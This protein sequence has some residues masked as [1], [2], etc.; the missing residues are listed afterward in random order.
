MRKFDLQKLTLRIN[1]VDLGEFGSGIVYWNE[2]LGDRALILTAKHCLT[3]RDFSRSPDLDQLKIEFKRSDGQWTTF[4]VSEALG[5][6]IDVSE[7][8]QDFGVIITD[9]PRL[10]AWLGSLVPMYLATN[11]DGIQSCTVAGFPWEAEGEEY[12]AIPTVFLPAQ[13]KDM[14]SFAPSIQL[15]S[16]LDEGDS[17]RDTLIASFQGLSGG[18]LVHESEGKLYLCAI[19]TDLSFFTTIKGIG[20]EFISKFLLRHVAEQIFNPIDIFRNRKATRGLL[21]ISES[22]LQAERDKNDAL[23]TISDFYG[24]TP[25]AQWWGIQKGYAVKSQSF[26][27][28]SERI[29]KSMAENYGA[30]PIA[31]VI[32]GG[33]GMGKTTTARQLAIQKDLPYSWWWLGQTNFDEFISNRP[34]ESWTSGEHVIV[35]DDWTKFGEDGQRKLETIFMEIEKGNFSAKI[36]FVI[37]SRPQGTKS[38]PY[39]MTSGPGLSN[40]SFGN[41]TKRID[42]RLVLQNILTHTNEKAWQEAVSSLLEEDLTDVRLFLLLFVLIRMVR[43]WKTGRRQGGKQSPGIEGIVADIIAHDLEFEMDSQVKNA[44]VFFALFS[45]TSDYTY[46]L[47]SQSFGELAISDPFADKKNPLRSAEILSYYLTEEEL[48]YAFMDS[49]IN[50][51]RFKKDDFAD[52]IAQMV[53][54]QRE[55]SSGFLRSRVNQLVK[56]GSG[57]SSSQVMLST[58][59]H[60]PDLFDRDE[61]LELVKEELVFKFHINVFLRTAKNLNEAFESLPEEFRQNLPASAVTHLLKELPIVERDL[62]IEKSGL[63][64]KKDLHFNIESTMLNV[65]PD[66]MVHQ[67][68]RDAELI[69]KKDL[70]YQVE[71]RLLNVLP[72]TEKRRHIREAGLIGRKDLS[73]EFESRLLKILPLPEKLRHCKLT[74]LIGGKNLNYQVEATLLSVLP[75]KEMYQHVRDADLIGRKDLHYKV[76]ATLLKVLSPFMR[77]KHLRLTKLLGRPDLH[78][79]VESTLLNKLSDEEKLLHIEKAELIGKTDLHFEVES[80]LLRCLPLSEKLRHI[81]EADLLGRKDLRTD[82]EDTMLSILPSDQLLDHIRDSDLYRRIDKKTNH[83]IEATLLKVLPPAEKRKRIQDAGL[84][85]RKNLNQTVESTLLKELP[86][87][88]TLRHVEETGMIGSRN[89][90]NQVECALFHVL[91]PDTKLRHIHAAELIGRDDLNYAVESNLLNVLPPHEKL[92]H[93]EGAK[94]I[95]K[96]EIQ[97]PLH[98][99]LIRVLP[100]ELLDRHL[101]ETNLL[102]EH[103]TRSRGALQAALITKLPQARAEQYIRQRKIL[104]RWDKVDF[105]VVAAALQRLQHLPKIQEMI[106]FH[107]GRTIGTDDFEQILYH[108][109]PENNRW[110]E[111]TSAIIKNWRTTEKLGY[112]SLALG[113]FRPEDPF[114][115]TCCREI[116][117]DWRAE[118]ERFYNSSIAVRSVKHIICALGNPVLSSLTAQTAT[119][120]REKAAADPYSVPPELIYWVESMAGIHGEPQLPNGPGY[121]LSS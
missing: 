4:E 112:V 62:F 45:K 90:K 86:P 88:E 8:E 82:V 89:L 1:R 73:K 46:Q 65:L 20:G 79:H 84:I 71:S 14:V 43:G 80:S 44:L 2:T 52:I 66:A 54:D 25:A 34:F 109:M 117:E 99:V 11:P 57:L 98:A 63:I 58:M 59:L 5:D 120:I 93:I 72:T 61:I 64:G 111:L 33:G 48:N 50:I 105:R 108:P 60:H 87:A 24:A 55:F 85:G 35:V 110:A 31:A 106:D 40:F 74:G 83:T 6:Q 67:H 119:E 10:E 69:G 101:S 115:V 97:P 103:L 26:S 75:K 7:D 12:V 121:R 47:S 21:Q 37:T 107:L 18:G 3:G 36:R 113:N 27:A 114:V 95:G 39:N 92:R 38:I 28:I 9:K 49:P 42:N 81:E 30:K 23:C 96:R 104:L 118:I 16:L 51:V 15:N 94:L 13:D 19:A 78:H 102:Q 41:K 91:P 17:E 76:E 22:F 70:K 56:Q 116:L 68:I 100:P 53:E 29:R 32:L 77:S